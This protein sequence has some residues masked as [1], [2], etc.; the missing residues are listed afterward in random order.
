MTGSTRRPPL[1]GARW[2]AASLALAAAASAAQ[3]TV[4]ELGSLG[5]TGT[6]PWRCNAQGEVTGWAF[7]ATGDRR[8]FLW[9][10]ACPVPPEGCQIG[11]VDP[12][13]S[14][15][16]WNE[17]RDINSAGLMAGW[18]QTAANV[19]P[20]AFAWR[21]GIRVD[22]GT[23]GGDRSEAWALNEAGQIVGMAETAAGERHAALWTV[24]CFPAT[25]DCPVTAQDLGTLGG[26][27]GEALAINGA[28]QVVG[29]A[30]N[31]V[32]L[33][34][35]FLWEAGLMTELDTLGGP[36]SWAYDINDSGQIAGAASI[37]DSTIHAALWVD[38]TAI[39]L[40][41]LGGPSSRA[42]AINNHGAVVG[43]SDRDFAGQ[44]GQQRA[45]IWEGDALVDLTDRIVG[46]AADRPI[47]R[48]HDINDRGQVVALRVEGGQIKAVLLTPVPELVICVL[49]PIGGG[50]VALEWTD[51][52][53]GWVYTVER[54]DLATGVWAPAPPAEQWPVASA[55]WTDPTAGSTGVYLYRVRADWLGP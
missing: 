15:T 52:G 53:A 34:R 2:A 17:G 31:A 14:D 50:S 3:Y 42:W 20:M 54:Q 18:T 11:I 41:T 46:S 35:A 37:D 48:A 28:G 10:G 40:G 38:G 12:G 45:F 44:P 1:A 43:G 25:A 19:I 26:I 36:Y 27:W 8:A 32:P 4:T 7:T 21:D 51:L 9:R 47:V 13:I 49:A 55:A 33:T 39:D 23:F 29:W 16:G 30:F 22:L 6:F 5:G 24:P